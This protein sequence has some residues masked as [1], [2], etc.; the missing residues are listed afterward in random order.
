M[1]RILIGKPIND[2]QDGILAFVKDNGFKVFNIID[3]R[4][5]AINVGL[6]IP[7]TKLIIF[8]NPKIGTLLIQENNDITFELPSKV[9]LIASQNQTKIIYKDPYNFSGVNELAVQGKAIIKNIHN[10]YLNMIQYISNNN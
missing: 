10:M 3:Q 8:G 6:N 4:A 9:L 5:E 1:E 7:E 2:I